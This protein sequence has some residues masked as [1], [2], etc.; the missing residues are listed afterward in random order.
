V[1]CSEAWP[2]QPRSSPL[3]TGGGGHFL[4]PSLGGGKVHHQDPLCL[5]RGLMSWRRV[6]LSRSSWLPAGE[7][8]LPLRC[9]LLSAGLLSAGLHSLPLMTSTPLLE[10][11][12]SIRP[13][14]HCLRW[15]R[16]HGL[17]GRSFLHSW[18]GCDKRK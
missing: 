15:K 10:E 16:R 12:A 2:Q 6:R 5:K 8:A 1:K 14:C 3:K 11:E 13:R 9:L 7:L 4:G 18:C 17:G